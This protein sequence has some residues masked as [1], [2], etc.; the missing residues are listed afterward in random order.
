[1]NGVGAFIGGLRNSALNGRLGDSPELFERDRAIRVA[2]KR[3]GSLDRFRPRSDSGHVTARGCYVRVI[4]RS[5]ERAE[6]IEIGGEALEPPLPGGRCLAF[7]LPDTSHQA[8][9]DFFAQ[10]IGLT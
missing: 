3:H 5:I 2:P 9:G 1:V 6:P 8:S 7:V 10:P 4:A